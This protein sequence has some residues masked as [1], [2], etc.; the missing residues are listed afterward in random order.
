[1]V[2]HRSLESEDRTDRGPHQ[3][4]QW[5]DLERLTEPSK[6]KFQ[7]KI[8]IE[9]KFMPASVPPQYNSKAV[10]GMV[11]LENLGATCYL[12]ALLQVSRRLSH[13]DCYKSSCRYR[14]Y[15]LI[16]MYRL[17]I[18]FNIFPVFIDVISCKQLPQGGLPVAARR[19]RVEIVH[20][21]RSTE[22]FQKS[23]VCKHRSEH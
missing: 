9:E 21:S 4:M 20:H 10:T 19:G 5:R 6:G 23:S 12:N 18:F 3:L 8:I 16:I 13:A 15:Y 1:M 11:G 7:I 2:Y 22:R 14:V 17:F